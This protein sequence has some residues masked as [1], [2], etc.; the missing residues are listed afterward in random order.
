MGSVLNGTGAEPRKQARLA[1]SVKSQ[2]LVE[3]C[4]SSV[5]KCQRPQERSGGGGGGGV[6]GGL[7]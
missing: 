1:R 6:A 2:C 5:I 3:M 4:V 7:D